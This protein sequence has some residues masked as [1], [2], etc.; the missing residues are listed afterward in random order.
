MNSIS[1]IEAA[2]SR[3][4]FS[5]RVV[6]LI[7]FLLEVCCLLIAVP[8]AIALHALMI[9]GGHNVKVHV[10]A[11]TIAGVAFFLIRISRD[12]YSNPIGRVGD[13]DRGVL[14]DYLTGAVLS[15]ATVW[16]FGMISLFSRGL[17]A[18]YIGTV[19]LLLF[20]SRFLLRHLIWRLAN[21][22]HIAQRVVL[23]GATLETASR[24]CHMIELERLPH[25]S[26]VGIA[27]E[28][29][30]LPR[31][32]SLA[33]AP[34]LGSIDAILAL[35]RAGQIDQVLIAHTDL[36][37]ERLDA[38]VEKLS[39]VAIDISVIPREALVLSSGYRVNFL[40]LGTRFL[41]LAAA[42]AGFRCGA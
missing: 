4:R 33:A 22:G 24:A 29:G 3:Y 39:Q 31:G 34:V 11:A 15:I 42:S 28:L 30:E 14:S 40:G 10:T 9:G 41:A 12:A 38:I 6:P 8:I 7:A 21:A 16:Q 27:D 17:T 13:A 1:L 20:M 5:S 26:I 35:A 23:F 25:L 36:T 32:S 18:F 37:Q 2:P 19:L